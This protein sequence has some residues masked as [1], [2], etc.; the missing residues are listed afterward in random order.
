MVFTEEEWKGSAFLPYISWCSIFPPILDTYQTSVFHF[1]CVL[2]T[3]SLSRNV[4]LAPLT[5]QEMFL[6]CG[7]K[8]IWIYWA[9]LQK[10]RESKG[11]QKQGRLDRGMYFIFCIQLISV[12]ATSWCHYIIIKCR[13]KEPKTS[14]V[15]SKSCCCFDNGLTFPA[16]CWSSLGESCWTVHYRYTHWILKKRENAFTVTCRLPFTLLVVIAFR[17]IKQ[18]VFVYRKKN[19]ASITSLGRSGKIILKNG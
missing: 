16:V 9:K 3:L 19:T 10:G 8:A 6:C 5:G 1:D 11:K 18:W 13:N 2:R 4:K 7:M 14:W 12:C 17:S 15:K